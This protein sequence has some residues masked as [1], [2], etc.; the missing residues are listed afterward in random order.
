MARYV[1]VKRPSDGP[2]NANASVI[3]TGLT[4][5]PALFRLPRELR[6]IIY[7]QYVRTDGGY[8]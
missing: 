6:D 7:E 4:L 1:C 2:S 8:V 3:N 5:L